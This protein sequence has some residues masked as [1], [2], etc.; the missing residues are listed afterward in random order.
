MTEILEYPKNKEEWWS[1]VDR[2]WDSLVDIMDSY[3][4]LESH[5]GGEE[6]LMDHILKLKRKRDP[7]I[8]KW[9]NRAWY[10]APD[11]RYIHS[12][13]HWET[14]CD[15]LSEDYVLHEGGEQ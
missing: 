13:P 12:L 14:L 11:S 3:L 8:S 6:S 7:E 15:L 5:N 10:N 4:D 1:N 2:A 9:F